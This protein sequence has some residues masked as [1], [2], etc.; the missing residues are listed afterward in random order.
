MKDTIKRFRITVF[1]ICIVGAGVVFHKAYRSV[2]AVRYVTYSFDDTIAPETQ[3][4]IIAQVALFQNNGRYNPKTVIETITKQFACVKSV[5]VHCLAC[6]AAEVTVTAHEP[7]I[8][9]NNDYVLTN[10]KTVVPY[11]SYAPYVL[12]SLSL[13]SMTDPVPYECSDAMMGAVKRC[14]K[15]RIFERYTLCWVNEHELRFGDLNDQSFS[16]ICD[17]VSLPDCTKL[18]SYEKLKNSVKARGSSQKR[19]VAD[20][21]F[22]NQIIMSGDKGGRYGKG[23]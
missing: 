3:Q 16:L 1:L 2:F 10:A 15:D 4:D 5:S 17:S 22:D 21:R 11:V 8:R 12:T 18:V 20:M 19:W 7:L 14:I 9:I 23:I 6:N 13:L